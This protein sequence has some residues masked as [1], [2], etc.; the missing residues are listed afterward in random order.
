MTNEMKLTKREYK[1][2]FSDGNYDPEYVLVYAQSQ[3]DA[4][5]LA[6]PERINDGLNYT[7]HKIEE[8]A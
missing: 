2:W 1:V 8:A 7:L 5:I 3:N 4:L 6:Q